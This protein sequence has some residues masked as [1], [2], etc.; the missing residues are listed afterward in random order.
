MGALKDPTIKMIGMHGTGGVGKTTMVKEVGN[1]AK[2]DGVFDDVAIA[3]V[4]RNLDKKNVQGE[5]AAQLLQNGKKNVVILEDIWDPL[6]LEEIGIRYTT[7]YGNKEGCCKVLVTSR[8]NLFHMMAPKAWTREFLIQSLEKKEARTL[9]MKT[10]EISVNSE[11][12][13]TSVEKAVGDECG[14]L[15]VSILAVAKALKGKESYA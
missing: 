7:D 1:V 15:P 14:G 6:N 10:A 13:M 12:E 2:R 4:S 9:F 11:K 5:L 8:K 3:V